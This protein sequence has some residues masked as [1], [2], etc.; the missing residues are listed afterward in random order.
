MDDLWWGLP[1]PGGFV[2]E[3]ADALA[4]GESVVLRLPA[5]MPDGIDGA[6]ATALGDSVTWTPRTVEMGES[7]DPLAWLYYTFCEDDVP[8]AERSAADLMVRDSF[9]C[10]RVLWLEGITAT[11]WPRWKAFLP[12][13]EHS[14]RQ[15][16]RRDRT[17][18]CLPLLGA[19]ADDPPIEAQVALRVRRWHGQVQPLDMLVYAARVVDDAGRSRVERQMKVAVIAALAQWDPAVTLALANCGLAE[20]MDPGAVLREIGRRRG[21]GEAI[22]ADELWRRGMADCVDGRQMHHAAV[23]AA[24]PEPRELNRRIWR[25]QVGVMLPY[26][27]EQR[28][29]F[30]ER[31]QRRLGKV[32]DSY[33]NAFTEVLDLDFNQVQHYIQNV[34]RWDDRAARAQVERL[35][36]AR[37]HLAHL[38]PL[39]PE[40]LAWPDDAG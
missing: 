14:S 31:H 16:A 22:H 29:A 37:D 6:V 34:G 20:V 25:G 17:V 35:K 12:Q 7:D 19:C 2:A 10:G 33:R 3:V 15:V 40:Y 28:R 8:A 27:E 30:V 1:G 9:S 11:N 18:L 36:V 23:V 21:W 26:L 39:P 24:L 5:Y 38:Q 4:N 32:Y 13:F